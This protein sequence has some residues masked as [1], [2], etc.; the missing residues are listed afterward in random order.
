MVHKVATILGVL[1]RVG[2]VWRSWKLGY[3]SETRRDHLPIQEVENVN[4]IQ[5]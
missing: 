4:E 1:P 3:M 2:F 5:S